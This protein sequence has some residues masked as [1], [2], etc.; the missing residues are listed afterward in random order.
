TSRTSFQNSLL[1]T[2]RAGVSTH[3]TN[4]RSNGSGVARVSPAGWRQ[5]WFANLARHAVRYS[6]SATLERTIRRRGVHDLELS[7]SLHARRLQGSVAE[8]SVL[9]ENDREILV[10][11][12][13]FGRPST[14]G[15]R[16]RPYGLALRDV[17]RPNE[18]FQID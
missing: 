16:D 1:L 18:R 4:V 8:G 17:W 9:V 5:N 12:V 2:I 13:E 6:F 3:E 10:R 7:G 11:S 15:A 14:I